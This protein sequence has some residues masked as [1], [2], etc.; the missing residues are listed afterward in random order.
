M[1]GRHRRPVQRTLMWM[2]VVAATTSIL[3]AVCVVLAIQ[4]ARGHL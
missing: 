1:S 4:N 2:G 3:L